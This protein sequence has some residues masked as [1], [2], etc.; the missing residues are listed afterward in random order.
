MENYKNLT[1]QEHYE[2]RASFTNLL[3]ILGVGDSEQ[4]HIR[5]DGFQTLKELVSYFELS[6]GTQIKKYFEKVNS[7]FGSNPP[8]RRVCI[9][10]RII[11]RLSGVIWYY[12]HN[13]Y[14]FHSIPSI[15]L[16]SADQ[17]TTLGRLLDKINDVS[18]KDD[19]SSKKD[20]DEITLPKLKGGGTWIDF[21]DKAIIKVARLKNRRS[22]SL[23]YLLD[24]TER[25]V[26]RQ[27]ATLISVESLDL[28]DHDTFRMGAVFFGTTFKNDNRRLWDLLEATLINTTAY[29][30]ISPYERSHDGRKAWLALKRHFEGKDYI[31]RTKDLAMTTLSNTFYRGESRN[32]RFEDYINTHLNAH[33]KLLQIG[34][35]KGRGMD[36]STK[37]HHFKQNILP[38]AELETALAIGR[39][40]E[41]DSFSAYYTFLSTEVD[42]KVSR[43]K[44][45]VK[46]GKDRNVSSFESNNDKAG[47]NK[48]KLGPVLYETC[49]GKKLESKVYSKQEF[50]QLS[51][52]QRAIVIKLNQ[53]RKMNSR[54][55]AHHG[56]D[57]NSSAINSLR[58][59]LGT[60]GDAIVAGVKNAVNPSSET[61]PNESCANPSADASLSTLPSASSGEVGEFIS[62]SRKRK[63][64]S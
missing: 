43:R 20:D 46:S 50:S 36:E 19:G 63:Q 23:E 55:P 4:A 3:T 34:Y 62:N 9:P 29:N 7:T 47:K 64:P 6:T 18:T 8:A 59:E 57:K 21:R 31:E 16:L 26:S 17:A 40:K 30:H 25:R 45:L 33:K 60:L 11:E 39:S 44:Q 2:S 61:Q 37:I 22:V 49:E 32:Y 38:S 24:E 1:N 10:P 56:K 48:P 51:K 35:N 13:V 28:S 42:F 27:N 53:Q 52:N 15:M 41:K 14:T 12:A 54:N 5:L 58:S